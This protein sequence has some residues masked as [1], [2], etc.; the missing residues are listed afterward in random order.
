LRAGGP[1]RL[2]PLKLGQVALEAVPNGRLV[3]YRHRCYDGD[4][5]MARTQITLE[6]E[7]QRRVR[8]RASDLGASSGSD[9]ARDKDSMI[10]AAF[11]AERSQRAKR[12]KS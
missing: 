10:G 11:A 5:M 8:Q 3:P 2:H 9:M 6:P 1:L 4:I 7:S 12:R